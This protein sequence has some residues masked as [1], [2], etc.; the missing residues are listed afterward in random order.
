MQV[1]PAKRGQ[2]GADASGYP[3]NSDCVGYTEVKNL[4]QGEEG[5]LSG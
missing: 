4:G 3:N 2:N 1:C 5:D